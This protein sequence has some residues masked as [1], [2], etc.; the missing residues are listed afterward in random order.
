MSKLDGKVAIITGC[1]GGIGKQMAIKFAEEGAKLAICDIMFEN[2]QETAR[3]CEDKGAE[4]LILKVN[5]TKYEELENLVNQTVDRFGT[6]DILVNNA[7]GGHLPDG[8]NENLPFID[9]PI[10]YYQ[11]YL[12]GNLYSTINMMRLCFPYMK[13]KTDASVI[14]F[15]SCASKGMNGLGYKMPAM[16]TAKGAVADMSR[17]AAYDWGQY[18]VRVNIV[19]PGVVTDTILATSEDNGFSVDKLLPMMADNPMKRAGNPYDDV[20][21]VAVFLAS[22]DSNFMTGQSIYVNGGNWMAV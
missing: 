20:A 18:N 4:V 13:G 6:I 8:Q 11:F 7:H 15:S 21:P 2:L 12:E 16:G 19:Y 9:T 1:A 22:Q 5:V 3:I 14:N 17:L 10:S